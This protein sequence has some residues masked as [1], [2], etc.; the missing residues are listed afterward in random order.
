M[1]ERSKLVLADDVVS[2]R[3]FLKLRSLLYVDV[4]AR[5]EHEKLLQRWPLMGEMHRLAQQRDRDPE[6]PS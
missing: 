1:Q 6:L 4:V 5:E 3:E 2:L